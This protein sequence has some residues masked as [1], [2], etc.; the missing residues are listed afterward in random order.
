MHHYL[1]KTKW[2]PQLPTLWFS[3]PRIFKGQYT[4]QSNVTHKKNFL[5]NIRIRHF[6]DLKDAF[7][8]R[9][10]KYEDLDYQF[11]RAMSVDSKAL[12]QTKEKPATQENLPRVVTFN[13]TLPN[14]KNV[15]DKH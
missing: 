10:F 3:K 5:W 2:S 15:I 7:M 1:H 8:K 6:K 4:T 14:I 11:E 12:L 9:G 13:E